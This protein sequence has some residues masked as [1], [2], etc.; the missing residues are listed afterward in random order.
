MIY[1]SPD[2]LVKMEMEA[3]EKIMEIYCSRYET[4]NRSWHSGRQAFNS[5]RLASFC[6]CVQ[7]NNNNVNPTPDGNKGFDDILDLSKQLIPRVLIRI[8]SDPSGVHLL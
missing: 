3:D 6:K 5:S 2:L 8:Q 1:K 4:S 7:N